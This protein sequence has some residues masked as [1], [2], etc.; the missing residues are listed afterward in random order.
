MKKRNILFSIVTCLF[1]LL[2][3]TGC[4]KKVAI[5]A[6]DFKTK[7]EE[8]NYK[9]TDISNRYTDYNFFTTALLA[10]G[11]NGLEIEFYVLN[12]DD[13]AQSIFMSNEAT[14]KGFRGTTNVE[15]SVSMGNYSTYELT[16]GG[17]YMYLCRVDNTVLYVKVSDNLKKEIK[18]FVKE[19][20]Y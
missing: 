1:M 8:H 17:N 4:S 3:L 18:D 7:A 10:Q 11:D 2:C 16:T 9:V 12:N 15:N 14:F 5:T 13:S 19:L 6:D 20:G